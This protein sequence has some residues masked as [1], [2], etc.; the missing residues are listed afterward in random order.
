MHPPNREEGLVCEKGGGKSVHY[1]SQRPV[2]YLFLSTAEHADGTDVV[3]VLGQTLLGL[4]PLTNCLGDVY[5]LEGETQ[6]S[7]PHTHT[8]PSHSHKNTIVHTHTSEQPIKQIRKI[9]SPYKK[10]IYT[11]YYSMRPRSVVI[12][13]YLHLCS[14][15]YLYFYLIF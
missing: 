7:A 10:E 13:N 8:H 2:V 6:E 1:A 5:R 4:H 11:Y 3:W 9:H 14:G 12:W 15:Q